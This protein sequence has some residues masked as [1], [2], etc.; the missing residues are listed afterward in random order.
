MILDT[1]AATML[2]D[3]LRGSAAAFALNL[4]R[5][6]LRRAQASFGLMWAGEWAATVALG[7][8]AFRDGGAGAVALVAAARMLPAALVAPFAAVLADRSNRELTLAAVGLGRALTLGAAAA[9]LAAGAP[10]GWV[11]ALVAVATVAQTLYRP[12]HSALLP[13]ICGTPYELTSANVVRGLLDSLA[14]LLG[15]L[16]AA[17][18][19]A[20][21]GPALVLA[22][23]AAASLLA[24]LLVV[25]LPY[26]H[27]DVPSRR[28]GG[29]G[30]AE[31]LRTIA[32]DRD[33]RLLTWLTA[34]QTF[35]RG[36][37][38]VLLVVVAIDLLAGRRRRR[39]PPQRRD[40]AR[41]A[42]RLAGGV[43]RALARAAGALPRGRGRAVGRAARPDRRAHDGLERDAGL[44]A[45]RR[46][47]R[48]GRHRR[49][50]AARTAR[51]RRGHGAGLRRL[52]GRA[53]ARRRGGR[54][55]DAA[56]D[57][58]ARSG[59]RAR[60][61]RRARPAGR[62]RGLGSA[63]CA[64]PPDGRARR[65]HPLAAAG[66]DAHAPATGDDRV[67]GRGARARELPAGHARV[68]GRGGGRPLL[69]GHGR[70][71]RGAR[72]RRLHRP[73]RR[74]RGLRGDRAAAR[75][76]ARQHDPRRGARARSRSAC[77][78]ATASSRR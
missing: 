47:Q 38:T 5:P 59:G 11:Y 63:A 26:E 15:P 29:P 24:G 39:R 46:R 78:R 48:P 56:A 12:A 17:A 43:G 9:V 54:C 42:R 1:G 28:T 62:G 25:R 20:A 70:G 18:L 58:W 66:A 8:I 41:R 65:R 44:R 10:A 75:P 49:V 30:V 13:S 72:R 23:C 36:A 37:V 67:P 74:R 77:S 51:A 61:R 45:R 27:A 2:T 19:L 21:D 60:R 73:A 22:A 69:R 32:R 40:R 55:G 64:R 6:A 3:A 68:R 4:R 52:R 76:A 35:T 31:G 50:H 34:V 33:M 57:R 71:R 14:T 7:V 16:A 53:H